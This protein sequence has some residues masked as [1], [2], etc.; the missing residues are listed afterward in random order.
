MIIRRYVIQAAVAPDERRWPR[1]DQLICPVCR[2][3]ARPEQPAYWRVANG[4]VPLWSHQ[5][6]EPLC[7]VLTDDGVR[8]AL[9]VT[10]T[11]RARISPSE[12]KDDLMARTWFHSYTD[13]RDDVLPDDVRSTI[14]HS[15]TTGE[16]LD[17]RH[18]RAV[19]V[20]TCQVLEGRP[21]SLHHTHT[22][23][24]R[25][26]RSTTTTAYTLLLPDGRGVAF[27]TVR[28]STRTASNWR[29]SVDGDHLVAQD[30]AHPPTA[31]TIARIVA[32][33]AKVATPT[34]AATP[35]QRTQATPS[36]VAPRLGQPGSQIPERG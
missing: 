22:L 10:R 25:P 8:P 14:A 6:R 9:P 2:Q 34:R 18:A 15:T 19:L 20:Q 26:W 21:I 35:A 4:P 7:P 16:P 33:A 29:I 11:P 32:R 13:C 23:S 36:R 31:K 28:E 27:T 3:P 1:I 17:R 24:A 5:D 30:R 12:P